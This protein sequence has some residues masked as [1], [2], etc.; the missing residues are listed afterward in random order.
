VSAVP[1]ILLLEDDRATAGVI[2][3]L[4]A[5]ARIA[6]PVTWVDTGEQAIVQLDRALTAPGTEPV[7]C[8]LDLSLPDL[9]GL[10]VLEYIRSWPAFSHVPVIMLSG[11]GDDADIEAAYELGIDAYL[12]KPAGV[13]GLADVIHSLGLSYQLLPRRDGAASSPDPAVGDELAPA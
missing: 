4:V 12:V 2:I 10:G 6:N 11:S 3:Q 8:V 13:H 5:A 7:L 9:S 1:P